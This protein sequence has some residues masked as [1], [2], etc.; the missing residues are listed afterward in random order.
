MLRRVLLLYRMRSLCRPRM[1]MPV[2]RPAQTVRLPPVLAPD[3]N[4]L[5]VPALVGMM[6]LVE[7]IVM[8][9]ATVLKA[10]VPMT[11]GIV[12]PLPMRPPPPVRMLELQHKACPLPDLPLWQL[13]T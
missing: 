1:P 5:T 8:V 11:S 3:V 2:Q 4:V 9:I 7:P 12:Q 10:D 13:R 6:Y